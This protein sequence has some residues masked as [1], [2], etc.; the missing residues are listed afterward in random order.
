[1][2]V[3]RKFPGFGF[4]FSGPPLS[5]TILS[6]VLAAA[7]HTARADQAFLRV[8]ADSNVNQRYTIES[9]SVG[10]V[11]VDRAKLPS[12]LRKR[13]FAMIGAR[14]DMAAIEDAAVDLRKELHLR[15]VNQRLFKGS[16]PDRIRVNFEVVKRDFAFD[17]SVP[18]FLYHSKQG[19]TGEV[20]ASTHTGSNTFTVGAVSNGDD[21]TE[22]FTGITARYDN[23]RLISD[24]LHFGIGFEDFHEQWTAATRSAAQAD[25][26]AFDLYR[27]RRNIAPELT[28]A[29]TKSLTISAGVSLEEMRMQD[30]QAGALSAN[31]ATAG[32]HFS[33]SLEGEAAR[34]TIDAKYSL[35]IGMKGLGSDYAYSRH[36]M[37][38]RYQIR[39]GRQIASD[40][41]MAGTVTGDAPLFER[42]VLGSSS[43]L[44]GWD[45][46]SINPL[47]GNRAI[48][49]TI[50][51]GYQFG[52][53]TAEV[54][55]D[56]GSLWN[57][58]RSLPSGASGGLRHSLGVGYRQGVFVLTMAFPVVEGRITPVFMAGMNY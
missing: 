18:K 35:R 9:V 28:F 56:M 19:P 17:I 25:G 16:A 43:T 54:F 13:L 50:T 10:G 49:N 3:S 57:T 5:L 42:F 47:G 39:S 24:H 34:Q 26:P 22:R 52:D 36:Q 40:E 4:V 29:P 23:T 12:G 45:R 38:F 44:R 14:C 6:V 32:I 55:Y 33:K 7:T 15:S 31:A 1:M 41:L 37:T 2:S 48:H 8:A 27:S 20:S 11:Q 58:G 53:R 21:L 30:P 51:Y 46:Y